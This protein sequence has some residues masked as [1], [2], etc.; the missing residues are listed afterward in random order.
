MFLS[1]FK[2][3]G[4]SDE[5]SI[6]DAKTLQMTFPLSF[7]KNCLICSATIETKS[8]ADGAITVYIKSNSRLNTNIVFLLDATKT[9]STGTIAYI[10]LGI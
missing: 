10:A 8:S 1:A 4:L 5:V 6:Y 9:A 2:Q 3:W 7:R